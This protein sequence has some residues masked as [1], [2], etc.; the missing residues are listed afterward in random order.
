MAEAQR[1]LQAFRDLQ[2]IWVYVAERSPQAADRLIDKINAECGTLAELPGMEMRR[3]DLLAG[4]R[5][6]PVANYLIFYRV[7]E[8]GISIERVV[9][10]ARQVE[11]LFPGNLED[12]E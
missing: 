12:Q 5:S 9:H 1:S 11:D 10:G 6:F 2:E 4:L 8:Q 3:D 7:I